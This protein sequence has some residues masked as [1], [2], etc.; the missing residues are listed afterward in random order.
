VTGFRLCN[1]I[2]IYGILLQFYVCFFSDFSVL[3]WPTKDSAL[4]ECVFLGL[5]GKAWA[6]LVQ[7]STNNKRKQSEQVRHTHVKY[8]D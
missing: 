2:E 7:K 8:I 5:N 6:K 4:S 1:L 3:F